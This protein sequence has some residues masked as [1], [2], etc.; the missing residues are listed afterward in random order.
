MHFYLPTP[1]TKPVSFLRLL[2]GGRDP[3][4]IQPLSEATAYRERMR[5]TLK[6]YRLD[7]QRQDVARVVSSIEAYLPHLFWCIDHQ[8]SSG[9]P[10]SVSPMRASANR[11]ENPDNNGDSDE[12]G[13][14][15]SAAGP[16]SGSGTGGGGN[17]QVRATL[18]ARSAET[19][20]SFEWKSPV[21]TGLDDTT[22]LG[23]MKN[24][25]RRVRF[26]SSSIY[27]EAAF[28]LLAY[29]I[30]LSTLGFQLIDGLT[31]S[32][33]EGG[34]SEAETKKHKQ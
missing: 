16:R 31:I 15:S 27:F 10:N 6:D 18:R 23:L 25:L 22:R 30:A 19:G 28:T 3:Q 26:I 9:Q 24:K 1:K 20:S 2:Q 5:E 21:L 32:G 34:L 29:G 11:T 12:D 17:G 14:S 33:G 8:E 13:P 4:A 7:A